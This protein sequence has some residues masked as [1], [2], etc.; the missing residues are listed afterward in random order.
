MDLKHL[1]K[2]EKIDTQGA[3]L[4]QAF[5]NAGYE[6]DQD[7]GSKSWNV[8]HNRDDIPPGITFWYDFE[9]RLWKGLALEYS[10]RLGVKLPDFIEV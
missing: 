4:A 1:V 5:I 10:D 7:R 8:D 2:N 3:V 6:V 9:Q